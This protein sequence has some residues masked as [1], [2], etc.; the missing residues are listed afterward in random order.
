MKTLYEMKIHSKFMKYLEGEA[1]NSH[2]TISLEKKKKKKEPTS[3][4]PLLYIFNFPY[5][6]IL[7]ISLNRFIIKEN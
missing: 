6:C 1:N 7:F 4:K 2:R 5:T 3:L